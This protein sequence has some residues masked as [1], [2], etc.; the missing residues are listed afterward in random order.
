MKILP[1]YLMKTTF[2]AMI[3]GV[4]G[5]CLLQAVFAYLAELE[6]LSDN[7]TV[8]QAFWYVFYSLPDYAVTLM[9]TG[10]LL[11]AV[12]GLGLLAGNGELVVMRAAGISIAGMIAWLMVPAMVF[13]LSSMAIN[14]WVLPAGKLHS[15]QIKSPQ[16]ERLLTLD[17]YWVLTP[18]ADGS[19]QIVHIGT[20]DSAGNLGNIRRFV[21]QDNNLQSALVARSGIAQSHNSYQWQLGDVREMQF[22][23]STQ[24]PQVQVQTRQ[25][26]HV[27]L[28]LPINQDSIHLLTKEPSW[29]SISELYAHNQLMK[30]QQSHSKPHELLFWQK[31]LSGLAI[32]S[33]LLIACSFV[34][35]SLRSHSL[36]FRIVMALLAGLLFGYLQDLCGFMALATDL[37]VLPMVLLPN[38][39]GALLG[40]YLLA[41]KG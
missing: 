24:P 35:G 14:Q 28:D 10:V 16:S 9:P 31:L 20:A 34:F 19:R 17:G 25:D 18:N 1:Y 41:K 13:I 2:L 7:Y 8:L 27:L 32:V 15:L 5:L 33:L 39:L 22:S 36:G 40:L 11:G 37:P 21:V 29:L 26:T 38:M 6:R 4:L 12:V 3:A 30:H 23:T